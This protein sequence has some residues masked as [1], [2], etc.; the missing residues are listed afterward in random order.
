M[1]IFFLKLSLYIFSYE[2][3]N[4]T[5]N[6]SLTTQLHERVVQTDGAK[7]HVVWHDP[8]WVLLQNNEKWKDRNNGTFQHKK[9]ATPSSAPEV[10]NNDDVGD[11][12][13]V[14]KSASSRWWPPGCDRER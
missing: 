2:M 14:P 10:D 1:T 11:D 3:F 5:S 13:E 7:R 12:V 6:E 4:L 9:K 8:C